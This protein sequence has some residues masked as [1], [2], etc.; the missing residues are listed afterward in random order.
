MFCCEKPTFYGCV[1]NATPWQVEVCLTFSCVQL[2]SRRIATRQEV[3]AEIQMDPK[4]GGKLRRDYSAKDDRKEY[5]SKF[6]LA[7]WASNKAL[8]NVIWEK[9]KSTFLTIT[10][11]HPEG[12]MNVVDFRRVT[13][14]E[15][16]RQCIWDHNGQPVLT[17]IAPE[18][19]TWRFAEDNGFHRNYP[20]MKRC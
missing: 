1:A 19:M 10:V 2:K 9:G 15:H 14:E 4:L 6:R 18:P 12:K 8:M 11:L 5:V 16:I 17:C 20:P 13:L 3:Y 7:P